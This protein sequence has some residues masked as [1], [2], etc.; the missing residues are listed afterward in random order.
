MAYFLEFYKMIT[1]PPR[2]PLSKSLP[3]IVTIFGIC[4]G[5]TAV[6]V[7]LQGNITVALYLL[8][9][10]MIL[11]VIDGGLARALQS[12]SKI[13]AELDTLADFFNFGIATPLII[14]F[15]IFANSSASSFGWIS[16][17]VF[18]VCCALRLA[19]FNVSQNDEKTVSKDFNTNDFVGVPAPAL[20][21]LGL[22]P[23]FF[24]MMGV[25]VP[26]HYTIPTMIFL[27][28]C[29]ALAVGTFPTISLKDA[30]F[31]TSMGLPIILSILAILAC[32]IVF[33]WET[34]LIGN[35]VYLLTLPVFAFIR[36]ST[37]KMKK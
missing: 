13:G 5:L 29:G 25:D 16:V 1:E 9:F 10:A 32:L 17:M 31:P 19:R 22:S 30:N 15:T 4:V 33:P 11:D 18:A 14:Y 24:V 7:A 8:I 12:E 20:A 36:R 2:E 28:I 35:A 37:L 6:K 26:E 27:V 34:L 3:N 21:C 23:L